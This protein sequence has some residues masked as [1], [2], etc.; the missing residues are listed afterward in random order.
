MAY[1]QAA[2]VASECFLAPGQSTM[3]KT[4]LTMSPTGCVGQ[5]WYFGRDRRLQYVGHWGLVCREGGGY[6][7]HITN[8]YG[9][10]RKRV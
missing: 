8:L 2:A 7:P 9:R 5:R 10:G 1:N 4:G 6:R 3:G